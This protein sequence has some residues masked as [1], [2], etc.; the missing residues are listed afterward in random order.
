MRPSSAAQRS[1]ASPGGT[2]PPP[3]QARLDP[4][5]RCLDVGAVPSGAG[6][7]RQGGQQPAAGDAVDV[8]TVELSPDPLG[9]LPRTFGVGDTV[10]AAGD[11]VG[12][13]LVDTH[14]QGTL[15][16]RLVGEVEV[17][18]GLVGVAERFLLDL[19]AA[20]DLAGH[21]HRRV[22]RDEERLEPEFGV[23]VVELVGQAEQGL[24][25]D[26]RVA[27]RRVRVV[28]GDAQGFGEIGEGA[29]GHLG[30]LGEGLD[31][32]QL[33]GGQGQADADELVVEHQRVEHDVE[34]G[35]DDGGVAARFE[36]LEDTR[37]DELEAGCLG[38][39]RCAGFSSVTST[40]GS[41]RRRTRSVTSRISFQGAC[42]AVASCL[43]TAFGPRSRNECARRWI[44]AGG[45][46]AVGVRGCAVDV[47]RGLGV[48]AGDGNRCAGL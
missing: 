19:A 8:V 34:P 6:R 15:S 28:R 48:R 3:R 24:G 2:R 21:A 20:H 9:D 5:E 44:A 32:E 4:V 29:A 12:A 17:V 46:V 35:Q 39:R 37:A 45:S 40:H 18:D 36:V 11:E 26:G 22:E 7:H 14:A 38:R 33:E 43:Q 27:D 31:L 25:G 1:H 23:G 41:L 10:L 16:A 47:A 13:V 42:V 30:L